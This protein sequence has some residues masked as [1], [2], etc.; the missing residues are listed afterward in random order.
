MPFSFG[1][2][3]FI[4]KEVDPMHSKSLRVEKN[5]PQLERNP[6][7]TF[8]VIQFAINVAKSNWGAPFPFLE[9]VIDHFVSV[10]RSKRGEPSNC[11]KL[12]RLVVR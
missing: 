7:N 12:H 9:I 8:P 2:Y 1:V 6:K 5:S 3:H 10:F 11:C 4:K